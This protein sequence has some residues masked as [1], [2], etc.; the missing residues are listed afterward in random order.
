VLSGRHIVVTGASSGIGWAVATAYARAGARVVAVGRDPVRL[1][2]L[3]SATPGITTVAADVTTT[4]GRGAVATAVSHLGDSLEVAVHC[5]GRLGTPATGLDS[6]PESEWRAV[7]EVNLTAM[8]L[9]HQ[10]LAP[11]MDAADSPAVIAVGSTV[12]RVPR[13]GWGAYAVSKGAVEAWVA[14][15]AAEWHRGRVYSVN[16]G[17]TRTPMRAAAMPDEDPASVPTPEQ[18]TPL[19]LRLAHPRSPEPS[20]SVLDARPWIG[21]DPWEGL[22]A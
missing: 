17:G 2:E 6:Y 7:F 19:F 1:E 15:L 18:V 9:L 21:K 11:A 3:A 4:P 14:L 20:G 10:Q 12:G 8:H 5:A 13:S 16:P 22:G